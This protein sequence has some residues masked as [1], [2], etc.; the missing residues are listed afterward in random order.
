M[1][2]LLCGKVESFQF[3]YGCFRNES[4]NQTDSVLFF[5]SR[6]KRTKSIKTVLPA[7]NNKNPITHKADINIP[8][9]DPLY[10]NILQIYSLF[11]VF[12]HHKSNI[13]ERVFTHGHLHK[14]ILPHRYSY[15]SLI[16]YQACYWMISHIQGFDQ[17]HFC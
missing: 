3:T 16:V 10:K 2:S 5:I 15:R 14:M 9:E 17:I 1:V 4:L 12:L 11:L 6:L 8:L 7:M 13:H